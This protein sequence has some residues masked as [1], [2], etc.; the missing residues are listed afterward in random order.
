MAIFAII[1]ALALGGLNT[2][3]TQQVL[4]REDMARLADLQRTVQLLTGD[5][6]QLHP[7]VV[8]DTLGRSTEP[9]LATD[10]AGEFT[11]RLTRGGWRNPAYLPRGTLQRVQYRVEDNELIREYW[12]VMDAPLGMEPRT[13]EPA[14]GRRGVRDRVSRRRSQLA[15]A[16]AAAGRSRATRRR[17]RP[18]A[19]RLRLELERLGRN[20]TPG[21][22]AAMKNA[23]PQLLPTVSGASPP[24]PRCSW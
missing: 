21:R 24:S 8:R 7:R 10:G 3:L 23:V 20:R 22:A 15:R 9:Y 12:P 2:V 19:I 16:M 5:F 11:V 18:R 6:S 14:G 1:S 4:A 13:T 17:V